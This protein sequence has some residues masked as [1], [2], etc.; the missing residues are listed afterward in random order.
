MTT[1]TSNEQALAGR[2][3][4]P[5]A[6]V[7]NAR[8]LVNGIAVLDWPEPE[9]VSLLARLARKARADVGIVY[10]RACLRLA[11]IASFDAVLPILGVG[12]KRAAGLARALG[13]VS[14]AALAPASTAL[15][16]ALARE[17]ALRAELDA[18]RAELDR[19]PRGPVGGDPTITPS[20]ML[21]QEVAESVVAQVRQAEQVLGASPRG[22]RLGAVA[23]E[24]QGRA[25]TVDDNLALAFDDLSADPRVASRLS[26]AF[27]ATGSVAEAP[28]ASGTVP[29]VAGYTETL[30]R[31]KLLAAGYVAVA[32]R[33][34]ASPGAEDSARVRQPRPV[35]GT[36]ATAGSTVRLL[37]A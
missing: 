21:L 8:E 34:R 25:R 30:A 3:G 32:L 14:L 7:A 18:L 37:I 9:R 23:L 1:P 36:A 35:A 19:L 10:A 16:D 24:V 31:R 26:L 12:E 11:P 4:L 27:A 2:W 33:G 13:T 15:R 28:P 5:A 17:A 29:D 6:Q 22:L 20:P